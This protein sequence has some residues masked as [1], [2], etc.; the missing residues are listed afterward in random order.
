VR[1]L[2][3]RIDAGTTLLTVNR[4]LARALHAA[5]ARV[6]EKRCRV[7]FPHDS[8]QSAD[9]S[10]NVGIFDPAPHALSKK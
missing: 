6:T 1:S 2:I 3:D 5:F 4:R 9:N 8:E 7:Y 10:A